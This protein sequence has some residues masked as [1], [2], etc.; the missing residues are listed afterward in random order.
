MQLLRIVV[1]ALVAAIAPATASAHGSGPLARTEAGLVRGFTADH[2]EKFLGIPY[3]A[4]P[5]AR[6]AGAPRLRRRRGT[7]FGTRRNT[8]RAARSCR[9]PTAPARR[10]RTACTSTCSLPTGAAPPPAGAGVHPR[11]RPVNGSGDQ[12]D[13]A[14]LARRN[15][16][17]VVSFNYRLG[18][19][20]FLGHPS[21]S[22]ERRRR[23]RRLG[24]LDQQAAIGWV[25]RNIA[26]FGGD[27]RRV[28]ID[29]E[30]AGGWSVCAQ[31]ASPLSAAC[32]RARSSRAAAVRVSRCLR[33]EDRARRTPPPWAART[34]RPPPPACARSRRTT[35]SPRRRECSR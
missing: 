23:V 33:A 11:R 17:V 22:A 27:P 8:G 3:A 10:T 24:V 1:V 29:G 18:V 34:L 35:C 5:V 30:S 4:A 26:A 14:V 19:F 9:A 2:T 28:T 21:L 13:G 15:G 6:G 20:G 25:H 16:I 12:H 31:L 32:S 7:A